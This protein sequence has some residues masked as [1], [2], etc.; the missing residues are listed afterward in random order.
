MQGCRCC[1]C[2]CRVWS[3]D[4]S[5]SCAC[6]SGQCY[7]RGKDGFVL[8]SLS[9]NLSYPRIRQGCR[10]KEEGSRDATCISEQAMKPAGGGSFDRREADRGLSS[11]SAKARVTTKRPRMS[12][13]KSHGQTPARGLCRSPRCQRRGLG[14]G[15]SSE[16]RR[17]AA[18]QRLWPARRRAVVVRCVVPAWRGE[19]PGDH[20]L[21]YQL[22]VRTRPGP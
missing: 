2:I 19:R 6:K 8:F 17:H 3:S 13:R 4:S 11:S 5:W 12:H 9:D 16:K 7:G 10:P 15:R 22:P 14:S 1:C 18:R 20:P 21:P